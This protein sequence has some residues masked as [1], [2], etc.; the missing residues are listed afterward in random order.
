VKGAKNSVV[1]VIQNLSRL[2][3]QIKMICKVGLGDAGL[4]V[5]MGISSF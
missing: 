2:L 3:N 4:G 5:V 1:S